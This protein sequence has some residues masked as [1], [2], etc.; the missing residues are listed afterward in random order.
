MS[1]HIPSQLLAV[2][3]L[4]LSGLTVDVLTQS[5][6][7][8]MSAERVRSE[9]TLDFRNAAVSIPP[10]SADDPGHQRLLSTAAGGRVRV[11]RIEV[12]APFE[13][14]GVELELP[15]AAAGGPPGAE[16]APP[17]RYD[18]WLAGADDDWTLALAE[19]AA[20]EA[21]EPTNVAGTF[22]LAHDT[23]DAAARTLTGGFVAT[24]GD[25]VRLVLRWG[26]HVWNA[27]GQ[28]TIPSPPPP[29]DGG[30]GADAAEPRSRDWDSSGVRRA[31]ML[32]TRNDVVVTLLD[33]SRLSTIYPKNL[34][35][36]DPDFAH[37][38]SVD[39]GAVVRVAAGA[40]TKIETDVP[41]RFGNLMLDT[42]S[43]GL[44]GTP[45][46]YAVWLKRV[47]N[48]WRLVFNDEPD[49]WGT[50]HDPTFDVGDVELEYTQVDDSSRALAASVIMTTPDQG[51]FVLVWGPHEWT[52]EFAI[53]R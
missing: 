8:Q 24:G 40:A 51:R 46:A 38:V 23:R 25:D 10:L 50:Q 14:G 42:G 18:M 43:V 35:V 30:G 39:T 32:S 48:G 6:A 11:A 36:E 52:A 37:L 19:A 33:G 20:P 7:V 26:R 34:K 17:G 5:S 45:G 16:L 41:L 1:L 21:P 15:Q 47:A 53:A 49:A 31:G 3:L 22:R 2:L 27:D 12:G 13:F 4:V 9:V 29:L 28:F 44:E